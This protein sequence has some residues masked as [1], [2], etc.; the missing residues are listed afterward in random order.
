[1]HRIAYEIP[2]AAAITGL[3]MGICDFLATFIAEKRDREMG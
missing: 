2:G 1:M 3:S